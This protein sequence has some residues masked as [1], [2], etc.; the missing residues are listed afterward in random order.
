MTESPLLVEV[1]NAVATVTL[2]RPRE[3]NAIDDDMRAA[4]RE[5]ADRLP[6]DSEIR[7][8][9]FTGAGR[10]FS[11]GGNVKQ[12]ERE[13]NP[14]EFRAR[15][16][17]LSHFFDE[18]ETLEKPVIAAL[19]GVATGAG[20]QLALAA[21]LRFAAEGAELGFREHH[22]GLVPGHGGATRIVKLIGLSRAKKLYFGGEL[23]D[24]EEARR[25]G[26]VHRVI[27][28]DALLEQ[29]QETAEKLAK[30]APLALGLT[31][32]LLNHAAHADVRSGIEMESLAQVVALETADHQEGVAAF[33]EKR[34]PRFRGE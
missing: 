29:V 1:R 8:V 30:R 17:K 20:L 14:A 16:H 21:D 13:W 23:V 33:R 3:L 15:S 24:A 6:F 9:V 12:F 34:R 7:V 31:K 32:R 25:I 22:L 28:A 27:P 18:L 5:L 26:L 10:A 2:N 11:A 19:N 4:F